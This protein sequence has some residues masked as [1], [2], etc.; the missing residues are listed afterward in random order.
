ALAGAVAGN[1]LGAVRDARGKSVYSVFQELPQGDKAKLLSELAAKVEF[2]RRNRSEKVVSPKPHMGSTDPTITR[3][4]VAL[5]LRNGL[6]GRL[7]LTA[8]A[9][10]TSQQ[11]PLFVSEAQQT[12]R[13]ISVELFDDLEE[14][15]RIVDITYCVGTAGLGILKPFLCASRCQDFKHFEL[16]KAYVPYPGDDSEEQE[17]GDSKSWQRMFSRSVNPASSKCDNCTVHAG[18]MSSWRHTRPHIMNHLEE[19][20]S[21]YPDYRMTLVGHSLGGAVAALA[22]LDFHA[23]GWNPQVTTFGEPRI[24]NQ[25]LMQYID[26][27]FR[28]E[29]QSSSNVTYRRVTHIGDPVPQ[30]PLGEW[31]Y[32]THAEEI[33]ISKPELPPERGDL[34]LCKGDSDPQCLGGAVITSSNPQSERAPG[35]GM[36]SFRR[37]AVGSKGFLG[38]PARFR[39]WQLFFAHRDY[40]WRLGLCIPGGDP[41]DWYRKPCGSGH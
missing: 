11:A 36:E 28:N 31:G 14:L 37:W 1:R 27:A 29:N 16:V 24:G 23:K 15:S 32:S 26:K 6:S 10:M 3:R 41:H 19:L 18:F 7:G 40:F 38:I 13:T 30:L 17:S 12:D 22:S 8:R 25:P 2:S 4:D 34:R 5:Y 21:L 9:A 35:D 39:I 33:Y 20:V